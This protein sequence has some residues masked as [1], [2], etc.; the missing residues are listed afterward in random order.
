MDF[1]ILGEVRDV[2]PIAV[3]RSIRDMERLNKMYGLGRWRKLKGIA[4][5]RLIDGTI[6]T[7]EVHWYESHGLGRK[8]IK[9]KLPL[10]D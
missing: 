5:V 9:L 8:E 1:E 7:A 6:H 3:G 10:R 4:T 2:E